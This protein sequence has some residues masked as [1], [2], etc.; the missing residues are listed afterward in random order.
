MLLRSQCYKGHREMRWGGQKERPVSVSLSLTHTL[1]LNSLVNSFRHSS[2]LCGRRE[3]PQTDS[4][5]C[6][7]CRASLQPLIRVRDLA[8]LDCIRPRCE[9]GRQPLWANSWENGPAVMHV[10]DS[11][12]EQKHVG[13]SIQTGHLLQGSWQLTYFNYLKKIECSWDNNAWHRIKLDCLIL[14]PCL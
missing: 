12:S 1:L 14:V 3:L 2:H 10:R 8:S 5:S 13:E 9:G 4:G 6:E 7:F 11:P